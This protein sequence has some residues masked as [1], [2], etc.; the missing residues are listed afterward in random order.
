MER[1]DLLGRSDLRL[2]EQILENVC[3]VL[4]KDIQQFKASHGKQ[5]P[6]LKGNNKSQKRLIEYEGI[7]LII[8]QIKNQILTY[9]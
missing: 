5:T 3:P 7:N 1:K 9:S 8:Y 2:L 6:H 4:L